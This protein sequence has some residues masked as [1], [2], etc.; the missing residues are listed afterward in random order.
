MLNGGSR[1]DRPA[2]LEVAVVEA[3]KAMLGV[4]S[5]SLLSA[6]QVFGR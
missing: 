1:L 6:G 2:D 3:I 5:E 4:Q